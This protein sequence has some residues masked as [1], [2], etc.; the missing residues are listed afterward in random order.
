MLF[1]RGAAVGAPG[2]GVWARPFPA[3]VVRVG[4]EFSKKKVRGLSGHR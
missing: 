1:D 4:G 3:G 2:G